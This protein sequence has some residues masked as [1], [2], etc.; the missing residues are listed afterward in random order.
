[1]VD[2]GRLTERLHMGARYAVSRTI[3]VAK[4]H[5]ERDRQ[6]RRIAKRVE[7]NVK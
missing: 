6:A 4:Q 5:V 7:R 1:M 3:K 2:N